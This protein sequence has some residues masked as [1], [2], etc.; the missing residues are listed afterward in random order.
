MIFL[1]KNIEFIYIFLLAIQVVLIAHYTTKSLDIAT[2]SYFYFDSVAI[3]F[4]GNKRAELLEYFVGVAF[5]G[6]YFMGIVFIETKLSIKAKR[7]GK[8]VLSALFDIQNKKLIF[9]SSFLLIFLPLL[10]YFIGKSFEGKLFFQILGFIG[11]SLFPFWYY[12]LRHDQRIDEIKRFLA[13]LEERLDIRKS[14]LN[15]KYFYLAVLLFGYL[16]LGYLFYDPI[17]NQPKIINEY[18]NIPEK[19]ILKNGAIVDNTQYWNKNFSSPITTKNDIM[20]DRNFT[21]CL[22]ATPEELNIFTPTYNDTVMF[23]DAK[24]SQFCI[25]G[26]LELKFFEGIHNSELY[27][28][29]QNAQVKANK[30]EKISLSDSD[31]DFLSFNKFETHWQILSRFMIHHNSFMFIPISDFSQE[32][33]ISAI[34]AQYGMGSAWIFEK[35]LSW[36]DNVSLDGWLKLSY[37]FYYIYFG[38]FIGITF[39]ITRSLPW[40]AMIFLLSLATVNSR[41]Y[42]FLLLPPGESPW[43]H[44]FDIVILYCLYLYTEKKNFT[45]YFFALCFG[46]ISVAINPQ[47][48]AMIFTATIVAGLFYAYR[49][50]IHISRMIFSVIL[51]IILALSTFILTSSANDLA[52]YYI[53]GVIGFPISFHQMF[54]I[55]LLII[56]GYILL[57]KILKD[58]LSTNYIYLIFLVIY[59]QELILYVIWHYNSD[60]F[61]SRAFIY[62]LTVVLLLFPFRKS[63]VDHWKNRLKVAMIAIVGIVYIQSVADVH[64][65]KRQYEKIFEHHVTYEWNMDRAHIVSTMNP[66]YFQNSVDLIQKYSRGQNG[67]YIVSEYDNLLPFLAH[68]YSLM[69]FFDLKWYLITPKELDKSIK[70][71]QVNKPEY[72]FIDTGIDRNVNNEIIDPKLP[73]IGYLNQESIWRVQRLKLLN[74]VFQSIANDYQLLEKGDLISVYQRK[75]LP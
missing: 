30:L 54:K 15:K 27:H 62:I 73:K 16:Q 70:T 18:F 7:Y 22:M 19:T 39:L 71:L 20:V 5:L 17:F 48:G 46:I 65:S 1:R 52:H 45:Y 34:N 29:L 37:L 13:R 28:V 74:E 75:D 41:G 3:Y 10:I 66:V 43:R 33:N 6:L 11:S 23:Y 67:I 12:F 38:L 56:F 14:I 35:F 51:A 31:T 50:K 36:K 72:I 25:N 57:W 2:A 59:A 55:F 49:E 4:N 24:N 42:D 68:R 61:K 32:K 63:I 64:K 40:T 44:I 26:L 21:N 69:P 58:R 8:A 60:G 9:L 47:I 53:D